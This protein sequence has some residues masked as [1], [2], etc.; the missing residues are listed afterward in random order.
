[1]GMPV[2]INRVKSQLTWHFASRDAFDEYQLGSPFRPHTS[3]STD[4][5][6]I[7]SRGERGLSDIEG[8]TS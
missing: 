7:N 3:T 2:R 1:M 4:Q 5:S 6:N 8:G